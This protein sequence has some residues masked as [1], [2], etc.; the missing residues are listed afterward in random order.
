MSSVFDERNGSTSPERN[1]FLCQ[2]NNNNNLDQQLFSYTS[3][4]FENLHCNQMPGYFW[5]QALTWNN[6]SIEED[7]AF[8]VDPDF[9]TVGFLSSIVLRCDEDRRLE[10]HQLKLESTQN[11]QLRK[12]CYNYPASKR[13]NKLSTH[14]AWYISSASSSSWEQKLEFFLKC[15]QVVVMPTRGSNNL[16]IFRLWSR[17][18]QTHGSWRP[19]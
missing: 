4:D 14:L 18:E 17:A 11:Q 3:N 6:V 19:V 9:K 7:R 12:P 1:I 13:S 5:P 10:F 15:D 8:Y 16:R 2:Q